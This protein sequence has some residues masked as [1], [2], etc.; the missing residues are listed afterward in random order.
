MNVGHERIQGLHY[1]THT[2]YLAAKG[3]ILL[4]K[5][6]DGVVESHQACSGKHDEDSCILQRHRETISNHMIHIVPSHDAHSP[7]IMQRSES[8][9]GKKSA[10][11][12]SSFTIVCMRHEDIHSGFLSAEL[13][14]T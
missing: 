5:N 8:A 12:W 14:N 7:L 4:I 10:R 3:N 6:T 9:W 13:E 2:T 11:S 1:D